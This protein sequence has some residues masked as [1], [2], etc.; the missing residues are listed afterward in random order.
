VGVARI[1]RSAAPPVGVGAFVVVCLA[2]LARVGLGALVP[3]G[4]GDFAFDEGAFT[5]G[6]LYSAALIG[7]VITFAL[8]AITEYYPGRRWSL[9]SRIAMGG[10]SSSTVP[11]SGWSASR[12]SG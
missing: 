6:E 11:S 9:L 7:L 8:V 3:E 4:L 5:F 1:G 10:K 12:F 2:A